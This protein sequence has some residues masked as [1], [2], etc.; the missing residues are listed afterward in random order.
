MKTLNQNFEIISKKAENVDEDLKDFNISF[1]KFLEL[2]TISSTEV[3]NRLATAN[4]R[5]AA[6]AEALEKA[7]TEKSLVNIYE[8]KK[9][10]SVD[11]WNKGITRN[12]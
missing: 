10:N 7:A 11:A 8:Y 12:F 3:Q 9:N 4:S 6:S 1:E 2:E 5:L